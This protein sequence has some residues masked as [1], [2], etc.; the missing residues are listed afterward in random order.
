MQF[1]VNPCKSAVGSIGPPGMHMLYI[2]CQSPLQQRSD[3]TSKGASSIHQ[4][5]YRC[6]CRAAGRIL[7]TG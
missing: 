1:V 7:L 3:D 2:I 4:V 5:I 6:N